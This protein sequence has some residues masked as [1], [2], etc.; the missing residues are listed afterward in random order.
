MLSGSPPESSTDAP[1][2]RPW[3]DRPGAI[4]EVMHGRSRDRSA[5][6]TCR[7]QA[8]LTEAAEALHAADRDPLDILLQLL[9]LAER[10]RAL[11]AD[12]PADPALAAVRRLPGL[13]DWEPMR[14]WARS[15]A[16]A[17]RRRGRPSGASGG[18][19]GKTGVV[20]S[21]R[22]LPR[23]RNHRHHGGQ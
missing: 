2:S 19:N 10:H 12:L 11:G 21:M 6:L 5:V 14:A 9:A 4:P 7:A 17:A 16:T 20:A 22:P 3:A 8:E 15:T 18:G 23:T 1:P 13:A